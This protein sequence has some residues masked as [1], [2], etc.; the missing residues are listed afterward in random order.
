MDATMTLRA[1]RNPVIDG[2][3]ELR[4]FG[5][6]EFVVRFDA[7]LARPSSAA[8]NARK[9]VARVHGHA[10][11]GVLGAVANGLVFWSD[12]TLPVVMP[13][14]TQTDIRYALLSRGN[15]GRD[16]VRFLRH[17]SPRR[18]RLNAR[19]NRLV[20]T[21]KATA[22]RRD[23]KATKRSSN[24]CRAEAMFGCNGLAR[25]SSDN[26]FLNKERLRDSR[27]RRETLPVDRVGMTRLADLDFGVS[28]GDAVALQVPLHGRC[29]APDAGG[30]VHRAAEIHEVLL[31]Q[32]SRAQCSAY[33]GARHRGNYNIDGTTAVGGN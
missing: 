33:F 27:A 23:T 22:S 14:P 24:G 30:N 20:P 3:A 17:S 26:V 18:E 25:H 29:A 12:A 21:L 19:R 11:H 16:R 2:K 28:R 15:Q 7:C 13:S 31:S 4:V 10:P 9:I 1:E 8:L 6:R 32:K 5:K